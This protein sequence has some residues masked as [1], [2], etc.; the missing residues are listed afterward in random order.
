MT[1][2]QIGRLSHA[3]ADRMF[4]TLNEQGQTGKLAISGK[5]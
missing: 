5:F 3:L 2:L 4:S 1:G